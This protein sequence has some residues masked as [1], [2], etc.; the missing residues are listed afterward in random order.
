MGHAQ[1]CG[2][3]IQI[4]ETTINVIWYTVV[5]DTHGRLA[6]RQTMVYFI[7]AVVFCNI[8]LMQSTN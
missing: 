7:K 6:L 4:N 1:K 2:G 5:I 8:A 3:V